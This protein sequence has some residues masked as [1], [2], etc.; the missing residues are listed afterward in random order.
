MKRS[1]SA[2]IFAIRALCIILPLLFVCSATGQKSKPKLPDEALLRAQFV[3]AFGS[4][5]NLLKSEFKTRANARGGGLYWLAYLAPKRTGYFY[6]QHRYRDSDPLY[7]HVEQ[8]IHLGVGP[9]GCHRGAPYAGTYSRFCLGDTI[10]LPMLTNN[11]SEHEFKLVKADYSAGDK[12]WETFDDLHPEAR[13]QGLD[14]MQAENPAGESLRYVGRRSHKLLHRSPGYTLEWYAE[15]EAVKPGRL[16]LQVSSGP[17]D[18]LAS[19]PYAFMAITGVPIIVVARDAP[20]T[21]IAGHEEVRGYRRGYDGREFVSST[22]GNSY[23]TNLMI[24]Q[25]GDRISLRYFSAVHRQESFATRS[26]QTAKE[27][28]VKPVI[29]THGFAVDLNYGFNEWLIAY[30]PK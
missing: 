7:S 16:N 13:D 9:K 1:L 25:P 5:F 15:F 3:N 27:D 2:N 17:L 30:L 21:M 4:D 6:L 14:K 26:D 12:D 28:D 8:E 29:T 23:M 19:R 18:P 24:L 11:F 10:I 22:S 20:V